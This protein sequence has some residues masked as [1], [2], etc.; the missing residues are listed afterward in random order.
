MD[1]RGRSVEKC[2]EKSLGGYEEEQI[3][4]VSWKEVNWPRGF[5][6]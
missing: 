3:N 2:V 1:R 5:F 6:F 4:G